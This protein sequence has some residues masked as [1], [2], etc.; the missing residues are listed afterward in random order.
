MIEYIQ[1]A[2]GLPATLYGLGE[3]NCGDPGKAVACLEG[4]TTASGD[5]FDPNE[6]TVAIPLPT[7]R[8]LRPITI[9]L[10]HPET[11]RQVW[12]KV[13][14][15]A[16]QRWIGLRGFDVTPA[17]FTALTGKPARPWSSI[18]RIEEC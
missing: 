17:V 15:K 6:L 3:Y 7:N 4:A 16:N 5:P 10:Q 13:N 9:C 12:V 18:E 14:D 1:L 2:M 8:I 11:K